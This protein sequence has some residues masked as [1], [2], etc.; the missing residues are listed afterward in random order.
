MAQD[1]QA[2]TEDHRERRRAIEDENARQ[3]LRIARLEVENDALTRRLDAAGGR[4]D[5]S[6]RANRRELKRFAAHL[7]FLARLGEERG[8]LL[9]GAFRREEAET[10]RAAR[11]LVR[12][13]RQNLALDALSDALEHA[14]R[15][16]RNADRR[17][18]G[19]ASVA[20]DGS[21]LADVSR[22]PGEG[23]GRRYGE[24]VERIVEVPV[25]RIVEVPVER[26]VFRDREVRIEVPFAVPRELSPR[27]PAR[28]AAPPAPPGSQDGDTAP[29]TD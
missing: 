26:V 21:A 24:V 6:E 3:R 16:Q 12:I 13:R 2:A 5:E 29:A 8:R 11:L 4:L 19:D 15:A 1:L 22:D 18:S 7:R 28:G 14:K 23:G 17:R 27:P 25:E 10:D 20:T 9:R